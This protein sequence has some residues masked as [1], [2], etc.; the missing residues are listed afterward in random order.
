M[1]NA[2]VYCSVCVDI[3]K[4]YLAHCFTAVTLQ[5]KQFV[6]EINRPGYQAWI[7]DLQVAIFF[8]NRRW[9]NYYF[10]LFVQRFG[11]RD[12]WQR[13]PHWCLHCALYIYFTFCVLISK[14]CSQSI[15]S[16]SWRVQEKKMWL[17]NCCR[18]CWVYQKA[19]PHWC[20]SCT[21]LV[22]KQFRLRFCAV[23]AGDWLA[24]QIV[25]RI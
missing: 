5:T 12:G 17:Q 11:R 6:T 8:K 24:Y 9:R 4:S 10:S 1:Q 18:C 21:T 2:P 14:Y 23:P 25:Q 20:L 22:I 3:V 19:L 15:S 7:V 16:D 13:C